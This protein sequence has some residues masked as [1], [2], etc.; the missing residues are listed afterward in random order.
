MGTKEV[1]ALNRAIKH[2][3]GQSA[4]A[5]A[6]DVKQGHVWH[7]LNKSRKVPADYVLT[8]E[9]ATGGAVTRHELRPDVF[10]KPADEVQVNNQSPSA[11][12]KVAAPEDHL[13]P[14]ILAQIVELEAHQHRTVREAMLGINGASDHL[15]KL[16]AE[17]E[18][19][20]TRLRN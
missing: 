9:A 16:E 11:G 10:G 5:R 15:A 2:L 17:I 14:N 20:R 18:E 4:L 6:C 7:W 8:I 12:L 13:D 19:L 3:G 1:V